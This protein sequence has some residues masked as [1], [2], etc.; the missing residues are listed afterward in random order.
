[1]KWKLPVLDRR[2]LFLPPTLLGF[3]AAG[4]LV[5]RREPPRRELV[6]ELSRPVRV[7]RVEAVELI[8]RVLGY[9]TAAPGQVWQAVAE[10]RGRVVEVHPQLRAGAMI[11][12]GELLLRIDSAEYELARAQF[13]ADIA[14]VE[15]QQEELALRELNDRAS[16]E[17]ENAAL[18]VAEAELQRIE[19][20]VG[21]SA[22]S[23]TE[24]D[25]QKRTVLAQRQHVQQLE[26]SLRLAPQQRKAA[27]AELAVKRAGRDQAQL[28]IAKTV[29]QAPFAC[30]L[31]DVGIEPGQF[32]AAG[33]L[34]FEAHGTAFSEVE[35][36]IPL[37]Q[38]RTLIDPEHDIQSPVLM[39]QQTVARLFN[40]RAIVRYR[41]GDFQAEWEGRVARMREQFDLRTRTTGLVV[42]VDKPYDQA[43]PGQRP[44]LVQGMYCEVEL[45]GGERKNQIVI[46]RSALHDGHVYIVDGQQ[47]LRRRA[48]TVAFAQSG[49]LCLR[50]GLAEGENVVVSDPVPAIEG[51]LTEPLLDREL[52]QRLAAQ[53]GGEGRVK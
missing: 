7:I 37:D 28:E 4:F 3:A 40:F 49:F 10:V 15:A 33:Q 5:S 52:W 50:E 22:A 53:A 16:L 42:A 48:V 39:D 43:V 18:A 44:P 6:G 29:I 11:R 36:Q 23:S 26:N 31:G 13:E 1:M 19:S 2:W 8:P 51:M 32:L 20:L 12:Q 34:L 35:T 14:R 21:R 45:H 46:P 9:G 38:L 30:R 25:Q 17:I 24:L 47:R 41:S 27:A